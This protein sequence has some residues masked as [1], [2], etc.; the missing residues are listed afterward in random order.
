MILE[1]FRKLI[2]GVALCLPFV[3]FSQNEKRVTVT[4]WLKQLEDKFE[5]T[6]SYSSSLWENVSFSP[7]EQVDGLVENLELLQDLVPLQLEETEGTYLVIP[8]RLSINFKVVDESDGEALFGVNLKINEGNR[9]YYLADKNGCFHVSELLPW[10][11]LIFESMFYL[12]KTIPVMRIL[13]KEVEISLKPD[14]KQLN[15]VVVTSY[16]TEGITSNMNDHSLNITMKELRTMAGE[17]DGDVLQVLKALPG[18]SAPNGKPGAIILRGSLFSHNQMLYDNIPVYHTGHLFGTLSPYYPDV[19]EDITVYRNGLPVNIG[20]RVGGLIDIHSQQNVPDSLRVGVS[21]NTVFGGGYLK[22]PL[23][24]NRKVGLMVSA[25]SSYPFD[26]LTPKLRALTLLNAQGSEIYNSLGSSNENLSIEN[27]NQSFLD[28]NAKFI[29]HPKKGQLI[30]WSGLHIKNDFGYDFHS[31]DKNQVERLGVSLNNNGITGQWQAK[32]NQIIHTEMLVTSSSFYLR[33]NRMEEVNGV[34]RENSYAINKVED[35]SA[36]LKANIQFNISH[37]LQVGYDVKRQHVYFEELRQA[38]DTLFK[39]EEKEGITHAIYANY[40]LLLSDKWAFN[41]GARSNYYTLTKQFYQ[42]YKATFSWF[43]NKHVFL[44]GSV[45]STH[46]FI[47][48]RFSADFDDF[49]VSNQFWYLADDPEDI[50]RGDQLMVGAVYTRSKW[51]LDV[52]F[53]HKMT[54]NVHRQTQPGNNETGTLRTKGLDFLVKRR[55]GKIDAWL[56]YS[57]AISELNYDSISYPFYDQRHLFSATAI[58]PIK[59]W[60]FSVSWGIGSGLPVLPFVIQ[61]PLASEPELF[62]QSYSNRYPWQHQLDLSISR[63]ILQ[64]LKRLHGV[65]S[66]SLLNVYNQ[67]NVVNQ[68]HSVSDPDQMLR[69]GVGFAP[70][71]QVNLKW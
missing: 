13:N 8:L 69:Y 32:W 1:G 42:D 71:L 57:L 67:Q 28:G 58:A 62:V 3:T 5:V 15:E 2:C 63:K 70:N 24:K 50:M 12:S 59:R 22:I 27:L 45:S 47:S 23:S 30:T 40:N 31:I 54:K 9:Y 35:L 14:E 41:I 64:K 18:L 44:K 7:P 56:S 37:Q 60:T 51:T 33:E 43:I 10:D 34:E 55:L 25:R 11:S 66:L 6:F 61:G 53:Y 39:K 65:I 26:F 21:V 17:S 38:Q 4:S 16:L 29:V 52:E 49:K 19:V 48:Q 46:Q 36:S 68:F 20:G